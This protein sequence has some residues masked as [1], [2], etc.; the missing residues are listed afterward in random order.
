M[1]ETNGTYY[2]YHLNFPSIVVLGSDTDQEQRNVGDGKGNSHYP[3]QMCYLY[4]DEPS[5][6]LHS[7]ASMHVPSAA[8][9]V[10]YSPTPLPLSE[11]LS[12]S[13]NAHE[14]A[15]GYINVF[16]VMWFIPLATN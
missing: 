10:Y 3:N 14:N 13:E 2:I 6:E 5:N 7:P 4:S 12:H 9:N 1:L 15:E 16:T 11:H 8:E